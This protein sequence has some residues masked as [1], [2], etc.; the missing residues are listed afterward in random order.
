MVG[1]NK[2]KTMNPAAVESVYSSYK[3]HTT[4][5]IGPGTLWGRALNHYASPD[6]IMGD[7]W[8]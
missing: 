1:V 8:P 3:V 6:P 7:P 5:K 2:R 4:L